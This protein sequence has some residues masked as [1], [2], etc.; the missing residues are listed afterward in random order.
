MVGEPVHAEHHPT[1]LD[2]V[3]RCEQLHAGQTDLVLGGPSDEFAQP[4]R[5]EDLGVVVEEHEHLTGGGGGGEVVDPAVVERFV[6]P[7]HRQGQ[8]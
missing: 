5:I 8:R 4:R 7:L 1:V 2:G 3:V 6:P